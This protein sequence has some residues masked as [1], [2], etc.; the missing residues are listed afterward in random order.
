[1]SEILNTGRI[2]LTDNNP[3]QL[4][5]QS[6]NA[7]AGS[8]RFDSGNYTEQKYNEIYHTVDLYLD[9]SGDFDNPRRYF[10]NPAS[11][12]GLQISDTANDW[13]ADGVDACVW[14]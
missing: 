5:S 7:Q 2:S 11:V 13:V 10:I 4:F 12:I 9:N 6:S 8:S 14:A 1:M 3:V